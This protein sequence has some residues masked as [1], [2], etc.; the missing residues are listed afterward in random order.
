MAPVRIRE[1]PRVSDLEAKLIGCSPQRDLPH[2]VEYFVGIVSLELFGIKEDDTL[3]HEPESSAPKYSREYKDWE[4][5]WR[6]HED[7][8]ISPDLTDDEAVVYFE[9]LGL[10]FTDSRGQPLRSVMWLRR[11][12]EAAAKQLMGNMPDAATLAEDKLKVD[13]EAFLRTRK[14]RPAA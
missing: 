3:F 14:T 12:A 5:R 1:F 4:D 6:K 2:D 11:Q 9:A 8:Y 13:R 10:D 7:Q